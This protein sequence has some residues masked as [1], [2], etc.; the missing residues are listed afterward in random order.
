MFALKLWAISSVR[1]RLN[2]ST[3]WV[4]SEIVATDFS[5]SAMD[6]SELKVRMT[7]DG[8]KINTLRW[9]NP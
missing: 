4:S 1:S 6:S 8:F 9:P 3:M 5:V 2:E 7:I